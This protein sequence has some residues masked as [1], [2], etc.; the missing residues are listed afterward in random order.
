VVQDS[1]AKRLDQF[2]IDERLAS[3]NLIFRSWVVNVKF[4]DHVPVVF[5]IDQGKENKVY[6]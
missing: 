2:L 6:V 5:Q 4:S 1:V 3:S